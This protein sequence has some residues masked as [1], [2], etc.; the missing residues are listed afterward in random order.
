MIIEIVFVLFI[1]IL[2]FNTLYD[3]NFNYNRNGVQEAHLDLDVKLDK[4]II[5]ILKILKI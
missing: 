4:N 5:K 1:F 2:V 3:I